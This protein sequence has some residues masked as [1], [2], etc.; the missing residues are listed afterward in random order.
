[1]AD[2]VRLSLKTTAATAPSIA[3]LRRHTTKPISELRQAVTKRQP[4]LSETPHHNHYTEFITRITALVDELEA[5]GIP[6]L[7]EVD[8]AQESPQYLRNIFQRWHD[9]G[10]ET[11][12]M[13]DLESGEPCIA[14]LK[15]LKCESPGDVFRHTIKQIIDGDG[16]QCDEETIA[17]ARS[18]KEAGE[19]GVAPDCGGIK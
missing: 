9:I 8:G 16:Y 10:I 14:T 17:W 15:W 6:Y 19:P 3:L 18:E 4:F 13:T 2:H 1:M 7:V 5:Q 11:E 12:R